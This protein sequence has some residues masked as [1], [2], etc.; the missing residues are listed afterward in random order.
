M[1]QPK[2]SPEEALEKMKLMM[3]YDSSK[4]LN[5]NRQ[6]ISEQPSPVAVG[7]VTGGALTG[8]ALAGGAAA[9]SA[10]AT[11][12]G[13][14]GTLAG[15]TAGGGAL[16]SVGILGPAAVVAVAAYGLYKLVDWMANGDKGREGFAQVISVCKAPG[17]SKLVP[18]MS[19]SEIRNIAYSIEDAKGNWND[20]E[21]AIVASLQKIES[22][23]DL[24][25]LDKK[26][27]GGLLQFLDDLTDSPD[28]WKMFT[29][30]LAGMIEDTEIVLTPEDQEKA[31]KKT[32]GGGSGYKPCSGTYSKGCKSDVIAKVQGCL[33]LVTD[34]KFGPKTQGALSGKGFTTFTDADVTKICST[35]PK[36]EF[37]TQ[38][39]ADNVDDILNN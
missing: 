22:I 35:T 12:A 20:D 19:K 21:D 8:G 18:K 14:A 11:A 6:I 34:G 17:A 15:L 25:A 7:A 27:T 26:V 23:A 37:D 39:D 31:K 1:V 32:D 13:G 5:E 4:T 28:E 24:C 16:L 36:D 33:G 9:A 10:A 3:K 2:Y 30:P 38:V 29:R